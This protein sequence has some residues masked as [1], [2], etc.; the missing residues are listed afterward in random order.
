MGWTSFEKFT[1]GFKEPKTQVSKTSP[2]THPLPSSPKKRSLLLLGYVKLIVSGRRRTSKQMKQ[3][4][5]S[6]TKKGRDIAA[7]GSFPQRSME[8]MLWI[9]WGQGKLSSWPLHIIELR[10]STENLDTVRAKH[11]WTESLWLILW[12]GATRYKVWNPRH[13]KTNAFN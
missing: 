3:W 7:S 6:K 1:K 9:K 5:W 2:H 13:Y 10:S 12:I 8:R 4:F 11:Y